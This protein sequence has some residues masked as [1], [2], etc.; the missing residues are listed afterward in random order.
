VSTAT[1]SPDGRLTATSDNDG[2]LKLWEVKS[3]REV[4]RFETLGE[5]L[6]C[7]TFSPDGR[8]LA[9]SEHGTHPRVGI[10]DVREGRLLLRLEGHR[11][12]PSVAFSPDGKLLATAGLDGARLWDVPSGRLRAMLK[13]HIMSVKGVAFS[14]DGKTLATGGDDRKVKLWNIATQQEV[15]TLELLRG[16]CRSIRFSPDGRTLAAGHILGS[17]VEIWLWQALS[18]EESA[19]ADR[20][21]AEGK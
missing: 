4:R 19:V 13:G 15:A 17:E 20:L 8:L 2:V 5:R 3:L 14:P 11:E 6:V 21:R 7:V 16:G 1:L 12:C 10:W 18:L 9:G